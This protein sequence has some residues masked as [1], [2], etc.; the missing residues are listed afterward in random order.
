MLFANEVQ[1]GTFPEKQE[2][3]FQIEERDSTHSQHI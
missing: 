3:Q 2:E 1:A